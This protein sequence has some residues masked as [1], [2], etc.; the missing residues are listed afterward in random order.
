MPEP[1]VTFDNPVFYVL[2][3]GKIVGG[4]TVKVECGLIGIVFDEKKQRGVVDILVHQEL[5]AARLCRQ[6]IGRVTKQ[7]GAERLCI[8]L[9]DTKVSGVD[10]HF[11]SARLEWKSPQRY[12]KDWNIPYNSIA[13]D[14]ER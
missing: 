2:A 10:E 1:P 14:N 9:M 6:R 4:D 7:S 3:K 13:S 12:Q 5:A 11:G 8:A